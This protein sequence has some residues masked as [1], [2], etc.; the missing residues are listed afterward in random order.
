[1]KALRFFGRVVRGLILALGSVLATIIVVVAGLWL[2]TGPTEKEVQFG[3]VLVLTLDR[4]LSE[5]P[6]VG[7]FNYFVRQ[8]RP[9][10]RDTLDALE[11]A[12]DDSNIIGVVADLGQA[13]LS[14]AQVQELRGALDRF[15]AS[16]KTAYAYADVFGNGAYYLATAFDEIWMQPTGD[17]QVVGLAGDV[18]FARDL[19]DKA[20]IEPRFAKFEEFKSA[21]DTFLDDEMSEPFRQSLESLLESLS[22]QM[23]AGIAE[24][25][26]MDEATVRRLID[27]APFTGAEAKDAGLVDHAG[28]CHDLTLHVGKYA[29]RIGVAD[30]VARAGRPNDEG[31]TIAVVY[32]AGQ[33][34]RGTPE[35]GPLQ[36]GIAISGRKMS[37][38]L[39]DAED[40]D[41]VEAIV[42]RIDSGGGSYVGSD[43]IWHTVRE[44]E[45]PVIVSM[46]GAAA[47]GGYFI[48]APADKIVALP[49][50]VT[51]SIGVIGGKFVAADLWSKLGVTWEEVSTGENAAMFSPNRDFSARQWEDFQSTMALTYDD[52]VSKVAEGRNLSPE[53][54]REHAKGRV[55]TGAQ[56][57]ERGLV[58]ALGGFDTAIGLA[59]ESAGIGPDD[60]IELVTFPRRKPFDAVAALLEYSK[61]MSVVLNDLAAVADAWTRLRPMVQ[62]A[63]IQPDDTLLAISPIIDIR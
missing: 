50:T 19:L 41:D 32:G 21:F 25:R 12:A 59:R 47:S 24:R 11:Q 46:A 35:R 9:T 31:R 40:D 57:L 62:D 29:P 33:I 34:T 16:G 10:M 48:A 8:S 14:L 28:Y 55:W 52:F 60:D 63:V 36:G 1:M 2:F 45:K 53:A 22:S 3:S 43:A 5:T 15:R 54:A 49:A 26:R 6:G 18:P 58:D 42:L 61:E 4:G 23:V 51:G 13:R 38:A 37:A 30:Y 20:G 39:R 44:I 56:A 27:R 17:F 7:P